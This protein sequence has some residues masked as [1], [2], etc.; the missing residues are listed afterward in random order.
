MSHSI[1][2][3]FEKVE[4]E[5]LSPL[6]SCS[7]FIWNMTKY[8]LFCVLKVLIG[9]M[10]LFIFITY[11]TSHYPHVRGLTGIILITRRKLVV[12]MSHGLYLLCKCIT[13]IDTLVIC[14]SLWILKVSF[15]KNYHL[16][17]LNLWTTDAIKCYSSHC[18]Q[19]TAKVWWWWK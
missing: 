13:K 6:G 8:A 15:W 2:S 16:K 14:F 17:H 10:C 19:T 4:E 3:I 11:L 9:I 1:Y 12:L 18:K 5:R 7:H